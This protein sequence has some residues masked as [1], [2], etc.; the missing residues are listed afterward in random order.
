[1]KKSPNESEWPHFQ[2][3]K[4]IHHQFLAEEE[5]DEDTNDEVFNAL[6]ESI[7]R[8]KLGYTMRKKLLVNKRRTIDVDMNKLIELVQARDII[9]NRQLKGHHNWYKLDESWKEVSQ[10]LGVTRKFYSDYFGQLF[11]YYCV[12]YYAGDKAT[13]DIVCFIS[14]YRT[15][16]TFLSFQKMKVL[17][18]N[19]YNLIS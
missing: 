9:W 18:Y 15:K 5:G 16:I 6:D 11:V 4:F 3:L 2:K 7:K 8:P 14:Y 12:I 10:Q 1:M 19:I 13:F 17:N